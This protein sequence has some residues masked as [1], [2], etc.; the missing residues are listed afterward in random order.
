MFYLFGRSSADGGSIGKTDTSL[1]LTVKDNME[2][3]FSYC[4][5][6]DLYVGL[7]KT[8]IMVQNIFVSDK[9]FN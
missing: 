5:F 6:L 9:C 7:W 1:Q 8:C 3:S 2:F 4:R